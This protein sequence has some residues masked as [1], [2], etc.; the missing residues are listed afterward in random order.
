MGRDE[1]YIGVLIDDLVNK[2]VD[3]PYRMFTSRAEY[4]ILLRQ[5]NADERLTTRSYQMGLADRKRYD[6]LLRK[7]AICN[8]FIEYLNNTSVHKGELDAWLESIGSTALHE[9]CKLSNLILR[10]QVSIKGLAEVLPATKA[11][12]EEISDGYGRNESFIEECIESCEIHVKYAGY[13]KR[14]QIEAAKLQRLD[15]IRIPDHF[16][17]NE[18]QSL[19]TEARQKLSRIRPK[20][21]GDAQRIP[22]VSPNDISV[23]LVL[24]GR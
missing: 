23:L 2:G 19:S 3:E 22:G 11:K 13:I 21:I 10:P 7:Q 20:S 17:F 5:D 15:Q 4:R 9:G 24:M 14:E 6:L 12:I 18:V 16:N 1:S 8:D